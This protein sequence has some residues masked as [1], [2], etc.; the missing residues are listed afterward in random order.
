MNSFDGFEVLSYK[1]AG[2]S[3][4]WVVQ[5]TYRNRVLATLPPETCIDEVERTVGRLALNAARG[6]LP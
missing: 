4:R 2:E 6:L 1:Q 3:G 5:V